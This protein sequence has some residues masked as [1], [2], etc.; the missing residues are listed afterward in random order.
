MGRSLGA[1]QRQAAPLGNSEVAQILA[2]AG[3]DG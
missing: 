3:D 2:T 1:R